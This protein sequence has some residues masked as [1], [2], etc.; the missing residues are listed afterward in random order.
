MTNPFKALAWIASS[1]P[2]SRAKFHAWRYNTFGDGEENPLGGRSVSAY[3]IIDHLDGRLVREDWP[4][5]TAGLAAV[6]AE[7][8]SHAQ[9]AFMVP[10]VMPDD[11]EYA[12]RIVTEQEANAITKVANYFEPG[13]TT[14]RGSVFREGLSG[15]LSKYKRVGEVWRQIKGEE[16][17]R[18][19][20]EENERERKYQECR[21][22]NPR[23]YK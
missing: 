18:K 3:E 19:F 22:A 6:V 1:N 20:Q 21:N 14:H 5:L 13:P 23:I 8:G 17:D 11:R 7:M 16:W 10:C 4:Q 9:L 15:L 12:K 2:R